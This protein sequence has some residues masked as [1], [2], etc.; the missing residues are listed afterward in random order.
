MKLRNSLLLLLTATIWGVAFVAQS[1][2][3]DYVGPCT[4]LFARS[5]I[6]GVVLLPVVAVLHK[7]G[8]SRTG[9]TPEEKRQARRILLI[10]GVCCGA[11]LCAADLTQQIGLCAQQFQLLPILKETPEG[12]I[13]YN[14]LYSGVWS[15]YALVRKHRE[16]RHA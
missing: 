2:G 6:G 7:N 9:E 13:L 1:V 10:G 12:Q 3:M 15:Q 8:P 5:L 11:A 14:T 16:G 4:F